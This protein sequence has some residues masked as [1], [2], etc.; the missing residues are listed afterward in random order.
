MKIP[1]IS[2]LKTKKLIVTHDS[3]FHTD[4]VFA[5]ATLSLIFE[6]DDQPFIIRRSREA[7]DI[8]KAD[9]VFDVGGIYDPEKGRFDHH[10]TEG[11]GVRE[12]GVP[13]ASFG[14]VWKH[15]G[16]NLVDSEYLW[17]S[18]DNQLV[19]PIDAPDN[20]FSLVTLTVPGIQPFYLGDVI[21]TLFSR[22]QDPD[23]EF[24]QAVL[25]AKRLLTESIEKIKAGEE[26]KNKIIEKYEDGIDKRLAVIDIPTTRQ[27]IWVSLVDKKEVLFSVFQSKTSGDWKILGMKNDL[28]AFPVKKDLPASWSGLQG[29]EL[30][31]VSGVSGAIFCHRN[32][33][34]ASAETKESALRMAKIALDN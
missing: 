11:A 31:R 32:L 28:S 19:A 5:A 26:I 22:G 9:I 17:Q 1:G 15:F 24:F 13:Y 20:G 21:S 12:N 8:E 14:L 23:R 33:F 3:G 25:F 16:M 29:E 34:L 7:S 30:S 10:Q 18:I 6:K 2:F 4:D 27:M